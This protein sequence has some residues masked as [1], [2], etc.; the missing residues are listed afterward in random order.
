[1]QIDRVLKYFRTGFL[2]NASPVHLFWGSFD[3]AVTRFSGRRAPMHPGG[4]Q[5]REKRPTLN[6][7]SLAFSTAPTMRRRGL[8]SG[9]EQR[10][11]ARAA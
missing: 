5:R 6:K 4:V 10:W 7:H 3:L 1:V 11:S 9:T 2:G 8:A